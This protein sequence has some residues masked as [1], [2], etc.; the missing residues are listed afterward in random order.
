[1]KY[2]THVIGGLLAGVLAM[3][4]V[5]TKNIESNGPVVIFLGSSLFG[6]L[7]P[8]IDHQGSYIGRRAKIT[9]SIVNKHFG[10]RGA[11][12][13]PIAMF[14]FTLILYV[15]SSHLLRGYPAVLPVLQIGFIGFY[16]GILSHIFL[17]SLTKTGV[18]LLYPFK[19][20]N[21]SLTNAKTGGRFELFL[22]FLMFVT[23]LHTFT[24]I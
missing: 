2:K 4:T 23:L 18:P 15:V 1:M 10:H 12:H 9:S 24:E 14:L 5:I 11:T 7:F 16:V 19:K 17:D 13:S 22:R 6:S 21:I 20:P 3:N 8:D